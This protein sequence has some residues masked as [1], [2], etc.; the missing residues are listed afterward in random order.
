MHLSK[1]MKREVSLFRRDI[2]REY[3]AEKSKLA[4]KAKTELCRFYKNLGIPCPCDPPKR[5]VF[6]EV[7]NSVSH[8]IGALLSLAAL[9]IMLTHAKT[10]LMMVGAIIYFSG[11]FLMFTSSCLY[12]A[13]KHGT[14]VKRIFRRF[15]YASVY[16]LIGATFCPILFALMS[17]GMHFGALL[18]VQW[19]V[20]IIGVLAALIFGPEHF[21]RPHIS[22]YLILGWS[23]LLVLPTLGEGYSGL[24]CASLIGGLFYTLGVIPCAIDK[25]ASHFIWHIFVLAGTAVQCGGVLNFLYLS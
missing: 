8:G 7:G 12:H 16:I 14:A 20:I 3:K 23:A 21:V 1:E 6:E 9:V 15:D 2:K 22:L 4:A 19:A 25:K 18:F 10:A 5:S 11:L 13:F 24:F 17:D